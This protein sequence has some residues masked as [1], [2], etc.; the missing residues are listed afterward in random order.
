VGDRG[1]VKSKGMK[2]LQEAH[3]HCITA[4]TDPQIRSLL[5][6]K[7]LQLELFS[8]QICEVEGDGVR[9]VLR[10]N[11][12]EAAR[13]QHRL[14]DKLEKL[15]GK[16]ATRNEHKNRHF[17]VWMFKLFCRYSVENSSS[18]SAFLVEA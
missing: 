12:K 4:L 2:A 3:L 8:E 17:G 6:Q 1:M 7:I 9:Y 10:K 14:E 11:E 5:G 13:E 16:I 18:K 15:V